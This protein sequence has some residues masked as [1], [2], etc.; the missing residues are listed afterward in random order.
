MHRSTPV[1]NHRPP[2]ERSLLAILALWVSSVICP[3]LKHAGE[4]QR[5]ET[6]SPPSKIFR[7]SSS[8]PHA[9][10]AS[11]CTNCGMFLG[12]CN[13]EPFGALVVALVDSG[14]IWQWPPWGWER[15]RDSQHPSWLVIAGA[16]L[17]LGPRA[18]SPVAIPNSDLLAT[19]GVQIVRSSRAVLE[20]PPGSTIGRE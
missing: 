20:H 12:F 3:G 8:D 4:W 10:M 2:T 6:D 7:L 15:A 19:V 17:G 18:G 13:P 16:I 9:L 5:W 14:V 1:H 11:R